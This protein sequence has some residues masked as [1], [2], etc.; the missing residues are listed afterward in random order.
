MRGEDRI[1]ELAKHPEHIRIPEFV[2]LVLHVLRDKN[3]ALA[4]Y[5]RSFQ[6]LEKQRRDLGLPN[7]LD[8]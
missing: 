1:Y 5:D 4:N 7:P 3:T 8:R 6:A 2:R